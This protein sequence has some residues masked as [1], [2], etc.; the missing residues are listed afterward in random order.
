MWPA[1]RVIPVPQPIK[2]TVT[3]P[4]SKSS[5]A[6]SLIGAA[7]A[8][9]V[10]TIRGLPRNDDIAVLRRALAKLGVGIEEDEDT[11]IVRGQG[12]RLVAPG[13]T[14]DI[15]RS[16]TALRFLLPL[17]AGSSGPETILDGDTRL[18]ERPIRPLIEALQSLG[19]SI[20]CAATGAPIAVV[21]Q[22]PLAGGEITIDATVS[23][24]FISALLLVAPLLRNGLVL[25]LRG[26]PVS[27]PYID[28]TLEQMRRLGITVELLKN[29]SEIAYRVAPQTYCAGT[30]IVPPDASTATYFW[31]LG[32]LTNGEITVTGLD[33]GSR[34]PD[35]QVTMALA[36]MGCGLSGGRGIAI[37]GRGT[38]RGITTDGSRFPD[39]ALTVAA[40]AA[41]ATGETTIRGLKTLRVKES[42][43]LAAMGELLTTLGIET[44]IDTDSITVRGGVPR[45]GRIR[46][47][48]DHRLAMI[49]A[50]LGAV[51]V[52][53]EIEAPHVV[54][55][56]CPEFWAL[57]RSIGVRTEW[58]APPLVSLI[59]FMGAGKST[60]GALLGETLGVPV[61]ELDDV[62][63][64]SAGARSISDIFRT[65]GEAEFRELEHRALQEVVEKLRG[66][67]GV[68]STGG[69]VVERNENEALLCRSTTVVHLQAEFS[70]I[71][72]RLQNDTDR[73]LWRDRARSRAL[74]EMRAPRYA[75]LAD[76]T[77]QTDGVAAL[78]VAKTIGELW[79]E[80]VGI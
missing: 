30:H 31:A 45:G 64:K 79:C 39:G 41:L 70:T 69:G 23:S 66:T 48:N 4:G 10:S 63:V 49:G 7:L 2:A 32:A 9:G 60:V 65:A 38:L 56:S 21:P 73:P 25:K 36:Q 43:R 27:A 18:R 74:F 78:E 11:V 52:G 67:G 33:A 22:G 51:T 29:G 44:S 71:E 5:G 42:D 53:V 57:L 40:V 24:Q 62:I 20:E 37:G 72:T 61:V 35:M 55:K 76:M 46:T 34:Q 15:H 12:G 68:I 19:A 28:L 80:G 50:V 14:I 75:R 59:G 47:H 17:L 6:R 26:S 58:V 1:L 3:I 16:G 8:E 13:G 77:V 54:R